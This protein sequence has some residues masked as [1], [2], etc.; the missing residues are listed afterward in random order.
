MRQ[1][2]AKKAN[3][4]EPLITH[5]KRI[6]D[7]ETGECRCSGMSA[8]DTCL[9]PVR[10]PV[11]RW[12]ELGSGSCVERGNLRPDTAAGQCRSQEGALQQQ[13]L[14]GA[15]YRCGTQGRTAP[16]ER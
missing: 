5:R 1:V 7:V 11:W 12:R 15:E 6:D 10:R 14:R 13:Q 4:S 9:L 3:V 8:G 16:Y 2:R